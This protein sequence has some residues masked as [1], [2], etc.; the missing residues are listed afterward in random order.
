MQRRFQ[1]NVNRPCLKGT[2]GMGRVEKT[3]AR[4]GLEQLSAVDAGLY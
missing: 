4:R 3:L 1:S 2:A